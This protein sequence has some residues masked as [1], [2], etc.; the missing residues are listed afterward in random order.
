MDPAKIRGQPEGRIAYAMF[1]GSPRYNAAGETEPGMAERWEISPDGLNYTFHLRPDVQWS[2]GDPVT[3]GDFLWSWLR[4]LRGARRR[5]TNTSSTT[6][7]VR[8]RTLR[9]EGRRITRPPDDSVA[10]RAPDARTLTVGLKSP[11][12]FFMDLTCV[13]HFP[14]RSIARAWKL[15]EKGGRISWLRPGTLISNG[16]FPLHRM[17]A[18]R[19]HPS[20]AQPALL[21]RGE[22]A[23]QH[24]VD[25]T[26]RA[27]AKHGV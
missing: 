3:A 15:A 10:V 16:P 8:G 4:A 18:E 21:G 12:P 25:V 13:L 7:A 2:N 20:H 23:A 24:H 27:G 11:T 26:P 5:N 22:C 1:E 6:S 17:A 14:C 19:S 9:G